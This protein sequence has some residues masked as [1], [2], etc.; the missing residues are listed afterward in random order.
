M[1][2]LNQTLRVSNGARH[3]QR[4]PIPSSGCLDQFPK[5]ASRESIHYKDPSLGFAQINQLGFFQSISLASFNQSVWLLSINQ[6]GFAQVNQ[7]G[8][9]QSISSAS[10]KSIRAPKARNMTARGK[11]EAKRSASPLVK[12]PK[13]G[14]GLKGRNKRRTITPFQG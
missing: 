3:L 9:F 6:F 1:H 10:L 11:R 5:R 2:E 12:Y 4:L 13:R 14:Q 7:L 8:F